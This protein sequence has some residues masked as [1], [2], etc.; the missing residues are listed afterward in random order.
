MGGFKRSFPTPQA[1]KGMLLKE[2]GSRI[3]IYIMRRLD[4]V[5]C[6]LMLR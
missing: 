5:K 4:M 6:F 1:E 2:K 3:D